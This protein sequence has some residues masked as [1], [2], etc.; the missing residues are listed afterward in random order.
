MYSFTSIPEQLTLTRL[1]TRRN[2]I[3]QYRELNPGE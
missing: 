1:R 3:S 2:T